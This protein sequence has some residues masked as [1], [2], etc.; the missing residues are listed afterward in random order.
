MQD[1][2]IRFLITALSALGTLYCSADP[3]GM[4]YGVSQGYDL[5]PVMYTA[6]VLGYD[7]AKKVPR[8]VQYEVQKERLAQNVIAPGSNTPG[9]RPDPRVPLCAF[10]SD[11][12]GSNYNRGHMIAKANLKWNRQAW[13]ESFYL[14]N[15][16]PQKHAFNAGVWEMLEREERH[17]ARVYNRIIVV[18]GPIITDED[19]KIGANM[20]DV[21]KS[22][23]KIVYAPSEGQMIAFVAS[24]EA[25]QT[26]YAPSFARSVRD[27]ENLTGLNFFPEMS[28]VEQD[29]MECLCDLDA[30]LWSGGALK[31]YRKQ[32]SAQMS[33]KEETGYWLIENSGKRHNENCQ[34]YRFGKGRFC[35]PDEG[36]PALCCG[37]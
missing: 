19:D 1:L 7:G 14:T 37:G 28:A 23:F 3:G 32:T 33:P 29:R 2:S 12:K 4:E 24:A 21:P 20:V 6:F 11:Y 16:C 31:R 8:W 9:F 13:L 30:W 5:E 17:F 36:K 15:V 35:R 26:A 18:T 10:D 27:V 22:F 25:L 34:M